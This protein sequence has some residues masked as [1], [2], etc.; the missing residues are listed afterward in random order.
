MDQPFDYI[1][2]PQPEVWG[3][4]A[5][6]VNTIFGP[7]NLDQF[8]KNVIRIEHIAHSLSGIGRYNGSTRDYYSV[9]EHCVLGARYIRHNAL[10]WQDLYLAKAFLIH[11]AGEAYTGDI[12][13][14]IKR[15]FD[16][17]KL[18]EQHLEMIIFDAFDLN[19]YKLKDE[20]KKY[21]LL[22]RSTEMERLIFPFKDRGAKLETPIYCWE[23][24]EAKH[25]YLNELMII[26]RGIRERRVI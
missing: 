7:V 21:D 17:I 18:Y 24:K 12:V 5:I 9:A 2:F 14:P 1:L 26:E 8:S 19:F 23:P 16:F 11:D 3:K 13:A 10:R 20:V 25:N 22:I 4:D 6:V 15:F